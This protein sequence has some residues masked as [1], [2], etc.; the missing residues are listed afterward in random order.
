MTFYT[1]SQKHIFLSFFTL[2]TIGENLREERVGISKLVSDYFTF[3][4]IFIGSLAIIL[5]KKEKINL[6]CILNDQK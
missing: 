2:K 6:S 4:E 1:D 3:Q 5:T